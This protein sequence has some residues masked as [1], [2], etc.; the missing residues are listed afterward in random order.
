LDTLRQIFARREE[1]TV[2]GTHEDLRFLGWSAFEASLARQFSAIEDT[3]IQI[4]D[5]RSHVFAGGAAACV[6]ATTDYRGQVSGQEVYL[7]G[8]R[9]SFALER[10]DNSWRIV[11][12]HW[13]IPAEGSLL[14]PKPPAPTL[15]SA[16]AS[17][18]H[19]R[20]TVAAPKAQQPAPT[21]DGNFSSEAMAAF[22]VYREM[23]AT[24][25]ERLNQG[26]FN[27]ASDI[28]PHADEQFVEI[29]DA[30][31]LD[32]ARVKETFTPVID[33]ITAGASFSWSVELEHAHDLA[34]DLILLITAARVS[35]TPS[36]GQP[37]T[38]RYRI[39]N[40]LTRKA[41]GAWVFLHQHRTE[42]PAE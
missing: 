9:L 41:S 31:P 10:H 29:A 34:P 25:T 38:K 11:Q 2:L 3:D 42:I 18:V 22:T 6:Y 12:T 39:T 17:G 40:L 14:N 28:G 5:F 16:G 23:A 7:Q 1:L 33:A 13:S 27:F 30:V 4:T 8:L 15:E 26:T 24:V 32:L 37:D 36:E 19:D 21:I 20:G 35:I